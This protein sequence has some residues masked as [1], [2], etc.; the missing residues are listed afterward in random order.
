MGWRALVLFICFSGVQSV[1]PKDCIFTNTENDRVYDLKPMKTSQL[2]IQFLS[3]HTSAWVM[4]ARLHSLFD[5]IRGVQ[6]L[7]RD[8]SI[9]ITER[10][11]CRCPLLTNSSAPGRWNNYRWVCD[12]IRGQH[13][14]TL[15]VFCNLQTPLPGVI[16]YDG[17]I[18]PYDYH[19]FNMTS[20]A[21]CGRAL[22]SSS[23]SLGVGSILCIIFVSALAAYLVIGIIVVRWRSK[24]F[25]L[26]NK[27]LWFGTG[28]LIKVDRNV[29]IRV[30]KLQDGFNFTVNKGKGLIVCEVC[31]LTTSMQ[32]LDLSYEHIQLFTDMM[33]RIAENAPIS[34]PPK[35]RYTSMQTE[36]LTELL[37]FN[38]SIPSMVFS[39]QETKDTHIQQKPAE[40]VLQPCKNM[41]R[42]LPNIT[43]TTD[44]RPKR[45]RKPTAKLLDIPPTTSS[46]S[47]KNKET[48][49][50]RSVESLDSTRR[51]RK[52]QEDQQATDASASST[53]HT[54]KTMDFKGPATVSTAK[55]QHTDTKASFAV[56]AVVC[57]G[58]E[59]DSFDKQSPRDKER[60]MPRHSEGSQSS[61]HDSGE[62][63]TPQRAKY[64]RRASTRTPRVT[65]SQDITSS[66]SEVDSDSD[67]QPQSPDVDEDF[68]DLEEETEEGRPLRIRR[69][70]T[71]EE[72]EPED[73]VPCK[74]CLLCDESHGVSF[75]LEQIL[76][77]H[78]TGNKE[79]AI[80]MF[81]YLE[82]TT[83]KEWY[84]LKV[85]LYPILESH[86]HSLNWKNSSRTRYRQLQDSLAHNRGIFESA[87]DQYGTHGSWRLTSS[88][89]K[90][91]NE[92]GER[93]RRL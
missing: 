61:M 48:R 22:E 71:M 62:E 6:C 52:N 49:E 38:T 64:Q 15:N 36:I 90:K 59:P 56:H 80:A 88:L 68:S 8:L 16:N 86:W 91:V 85:D 39:K 14:S 7:M 81:A 77:I 83:P 51:K 11:L 65:R 58:E 23:S 20:S 72:R 76:D 28:S 31:S 47:S 29:S 25:G 33:Q 19:T 2:S 5:P 24:E 44:D 37:P 30:D 55:R 60:R 57:P 45:T 54:K 78:H 93:Y 73:F 42:E 27:E 43:P 10:E 79:M 82:Y 70:P 89:R 9:T 21:A 66:D 92:L 41:R 17:F 69:K 63:N 26:P 18:G 32:H 50:E 13:P 40:R 75:F 87:H 67:C 12:R 1:W 74:G 4:T 46:S 84:T 53:S 35:K 3:E 34:L